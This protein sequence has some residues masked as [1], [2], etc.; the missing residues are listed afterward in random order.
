VFGNRVLRRCGVAESLRKCIMVKLRRWADHVARVWK[1]RNA[2]RTL[3]EKARRK[4][5]TRKTQTLMGG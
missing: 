3:V 5:T 1:K 2:Y 4:E